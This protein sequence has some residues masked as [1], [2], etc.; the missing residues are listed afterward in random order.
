MWP[1]DGL[2]EWPAER[3]AE[4]LARALAERRRARFRNVQLLHLIRADCQIGQVPR[5]DTGTNQA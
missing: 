1:A 3:L 2:A 5:A 4:W